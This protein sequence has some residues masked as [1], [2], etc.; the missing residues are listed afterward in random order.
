MY[1]SLWNG[2]GSTNNAPSAE[3][4]YRPWNNGH[5]NDFFLEDGSYFRIQNVRLSYDIPRSVMNK[6]GVGDAQVYLNADRPYTFFSSNGFTPEVPHG[7][8][9]SVYPIPAIFSLGAKIN[10]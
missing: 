2:V 9:H 3:G 6:I 4:L 8:D 1:N 7:I 5:L 10:F